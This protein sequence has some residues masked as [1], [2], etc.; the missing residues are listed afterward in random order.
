MIDIITPYGLNPVPVDVHVTPEEWVKYRAFLHPLDRFTEEKGLGVEFKILFEGD[1]LIA[2]DVAK[3]NKE[4]V[5]IRERLQSFIKF[6]WYKSLRADKFVNNPGEILYI[7]QEY[8]DLK[9]EQNKVWREGYKKL[10]GKDSPS[11][12]KTEI[13]ENG[14]LC[15]VGDVKQNEGVQKHLWHGIYN[16][17]F[18]EHVSEDTLFYR[19]RLCPDGIKKRLKKASKC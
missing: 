17:Y 8:H 19:R 9:M 15:K 6:P 14:Y 5:A 16:L 4:A 3:N 13:C 7:T 11:E 12:D 2:G 10:H 1:F 18:K